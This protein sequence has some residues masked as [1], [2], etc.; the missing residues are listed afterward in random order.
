MSE[1]ITIALD[2][3]GGDIGPSVVVPAAIKMLRANAAM[4]IILVGDETTVEAQFRD[5][6]ADT[7]NR[8]SIRHTT[9]RVDMDE[10]PSHALRNKKDSSMRVAINLV[11]EGVADA[12]VSAGNTGALMAI[13]RF[14]LK[15]LPGI[16]RPAIITALPSLEGHTHVLDLGAN[17]D[18]DAEHLVQ[19]AI[20]GS[21]L[22]TAVD[23]TERPR[24]GLLNVGQEE[25]KG[26]EVVKEAAQLLSNTPL[27]YIGFV[28][29]DDIF[30][31][32]ADVVVCD[33]FV[34]N[35]MLKSAEGVAN[36]I[37]QFLKEGFT[38]GIYGRIAGA[39]ALPVLRRIGGRIDPRRYN[40]ASLL[41]LQGT[42]IKSHG[43][44]DVVAF[45]NAI[46]IAQLEV[47]HAVPQ[48]I[49]RKL[50]ELFS[51]RQVG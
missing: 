47:H 31:G 36:M 42:V 32:G 43:A 39:L 49:S 40:G 4:R 33:G 5:V 44:A 38:R 13:A 22:S 37:A 26:N 46:R 1:P 20:M 6:P 30:K 24:V 35:V 11:K 12:C 15:T 41:G 29:G 23:K 14:V 7:R 10:L 8:L 51:Q 25:I 9:E 50:E 17:V 2:A 19:L 48:N 27:N 18:L 34:G 3:M 45:A 16:D 28:E 21:V